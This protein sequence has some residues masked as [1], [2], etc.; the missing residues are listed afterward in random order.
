MQNTRMICCDC[1]LS[2]DV[3]FRAYGVTVEFRVKRNNRSTAAV[4]REDKKK[5]DR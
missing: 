2:H 5:R 3:Q 4:R 1:G